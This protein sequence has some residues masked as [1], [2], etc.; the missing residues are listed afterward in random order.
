MIGIRELPNL[1]YLLF[2]KTFAKSF[3]IKKIL[4]LVFFCFWKMGF[5]HFNPKWLTPKWNTVTLPEKKEASWIKTKAKITAEFIRKTRHL[6]SSSS[7]SFSGAMALNL[8]N[9]HFWW[10]TFYSDLSFS[11]YNRNSTTILYFLTKNYARFP[12]K[13]KK[14][15]FKKSYTIYENYRQHIKCCLYL[16]AG[17]STV[18]SGKVRVSSIFF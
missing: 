9:C 14:F 17:C 12:V 10:L 3:L 7:G 15:L 5:S 2:L 6:S 11:I 13:Q 1:S 8:F 18:Y 16:Y 4:Y